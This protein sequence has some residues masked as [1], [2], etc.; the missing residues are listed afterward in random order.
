M[1]RLLPESDA[2]VPIPV[3]RALIMRAWLL[4]G[5]SFVYWELSQFF[6]AIYDDGLAEWKAIAI[7]GCAEV[8]IMMGVY[9]SISL[10]IGHRLLHGT[11]WV[12]RLLGIVVALAVFAANYGALLRNNR[13]RRFEEEFESFSR[14]SRV[15]GIIGIIGVLLGIVIATLASLTAVRHLPQ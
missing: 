1:R 6:K 9:G 3:F 8:L 13:W 4:R 15:A 12:S 7:L 11:T 10:V 2:Y 5:Y 14:S